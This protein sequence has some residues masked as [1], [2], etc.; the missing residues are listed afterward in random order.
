MVNLNSIDCVLC[1]LCLVCTILASLKW[2]FNLYL[3]FAWFT[4]SSALAQKNASLTCCN[5]TAANK[6]HH[7]SFHY[8]SL[9]FR[10][11]PGEPSE[12]G[13]ASSQRAA[14]P[15]D[16][17]HDGAVLPGLLAAVRCRR[18]ALH[19]WPPWPF[20]PRSEHRTV[21]ARQVVHRHQPLHLHFH[22]QTGVSLTLRHSQAHSVYSHFNCPTA[23]LG[24]GSLLFFCLLPA[25]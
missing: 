22:E 23:G 16:G 3:T 9:S 2:H 15:G 6:S 20:D 14:G 19:I 18:S 24:L 21:A 25:V 7:C 8:Y 10:L 5:S 1:C 13:G 12:F 4:V 11:F 17:G